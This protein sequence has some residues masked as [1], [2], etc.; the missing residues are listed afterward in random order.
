[1]IY[2]YINNQSENTLILFHGTGGS[3]DDLIPIAKFIDQNANI[4]TVEGHIFEG[5]HKRYFKRFASGMLDEVSLEK[6]S[7]HIYKMLTD[8]S[9]KYHF[10]LKNV[11]LIGYS[12]GANLIASII[13]LYPNV[14]ENVILFSAMLPYQ[15]KKPLDIITT[16]VFL[17]AGTMDNMIPYIESKKFID[18]LKDY[19]APLTL[20]IKNQGHQISQDNIFEARNFYHKK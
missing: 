6:E 9:Q 16:N 3:M 8:W 11:T 1:M 10:N 13:Y 5:P 20:S 17:S 15:S 7:N 18:V 14:F 2:K 19:Q 4:L 12:N